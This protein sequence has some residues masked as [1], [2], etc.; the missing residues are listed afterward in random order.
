M[1]LID[2]D[3][4][5]AIIA[6]ELKFC[7]PTTFELPFVEFETQIKMVSLKLNLATFAFLPSRVLMGHYNVIY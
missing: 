2:H 6:V 3:V 4:T 7:V 1:H 5:F